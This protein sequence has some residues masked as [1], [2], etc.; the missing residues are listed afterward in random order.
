MTQSALFR[1]EVLEARR[2][3]WLGA[4]RL[5]QSVPFWS[6]SAAALLMAVSLIVYGIFGTYARK[7]RVA[8]VLAAQGGEINIA[9]PN[10]GILAELRV[11]EGDEVSAGQVL[12][13][14]N[15]D[16]TVATGSS[17]TGFDDAASLL[18]QRIAIRRDA[19]ATDAN[20]RRTQTQVRR[21]SLSERVSRIDAELLKLGDEIAIQARRR[22]Y[23]EQSVKRYEELVSANFVSPLQ[24]Q[25]QQESLL[26]QE[27]RLSTLERTRLSIL[28]ERG[29]LVADMQ[30]ADAD[31]AASLVAIERD[32]ATLEQEATENTSRRTSVVTAARDGTVSA[33]A[34]APGQWIAAGQNLAA[35]Q[36][37]GMGLEA[38][39]YAPSHAAGFV[40]PGQSVQ[41]RYAAYPY[42]KFG[43]Q[44]GTV[45][46]IS[47]SAFAPTDL[48]PALQAQFGRQTTEAIYRVT[49]SLSAQT[50]STYG[51]YRPLKAGMSIEADI[52]Q[53]QRSI[54]EWMLEPLFAAATRS[55][56]KI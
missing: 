33:L 52:V 14:L 34:V 32:R 27:G 8:G 5:A 38:Q 30:Q 25:S 54:I 12:M 2:E 47:H 15:T 10:A 37:R 13:V 35:I 22:A 29:T 20:L 19:L 16:R 18:E 53:D 44:A 48:P 26:D 46:A 7:V 42:Q 50:I 24:A 49:V 51:E 45:S 1:Q 41:L 3:Q 28:R 11:K 4:V 40:V 23:A 6:A 36:P 21:Q 9:A 31:L 43:L 55:A 17:N 56:S 39:L